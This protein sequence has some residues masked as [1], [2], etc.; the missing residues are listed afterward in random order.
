MSLTCFTTNYVAN[1]SV[2]LGIMTKQLG[3]SSPSPTLQCPS[4]AKLVQVSN[5]TC[6]LYLR[7]DLFVYRR[8]Y[9]HGLANAIPER[10]YATLLKIPSQAKAGDLSYQSPSIT[11]KTLLQLFVHRIPPTKETS[12]IT[13]SL[14]GSATTV[15]CFLPLRCPPP[16]Y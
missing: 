5:L 12:L 11:I 16:N 7:R 3:K 10:S 14:S 4:T 6:I 8:G 1:T 15:P 9:G 13:M 2:H